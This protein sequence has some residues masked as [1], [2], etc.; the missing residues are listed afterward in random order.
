MLWVRDP[1]TA[2]IGTHQKLY[3]MQN[4]AFTSLQESL[5]VTSSSPGEH[6]EQNVDWRAVLLL[7]VLLL[8][9][10][11][12]LLLLVLELLV[13]LVVQEIRRWLSCWWLV[14]GATRDAWTLLRKRQVLRQRG[15]ALRL[16]V[17]AV[18]VDVRVVLSGRR[19]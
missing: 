12:L 13:L 17:G 10:V 9:E 4:V 3:S 7:L 15:L 8:L 16:G 1:T 18:A 14:P 19:C 2:T 5:Y 6:P 11:L